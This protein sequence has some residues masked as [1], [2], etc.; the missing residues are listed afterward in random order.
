MISDLKV[1]FSRSYISSLLL[2]FHSK[3]MTPK[4]CLTRNFSL[5]LQRRLSKIM[6]VKG[7]KL[8]SSFYFA[9]FDQ[10]KSSFKQQI[11]ARI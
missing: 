11:F 5:H 3:N 6:E 7:P 2:L 10:L 1:W 8:S 9:D 4:N